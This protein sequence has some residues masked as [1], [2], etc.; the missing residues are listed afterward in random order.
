MVWASLINLLFKMFI[1][2]IVLI[3]PDSPYLSFPLAFPSLGLLYISYYLK[4]NNYSPIFYDLTGGIKLPENL[5]AD[6]FAFSCQITQFKEIINIMKILR[7]DNPNSLFVVG[8]PFPTHSPEE[9]L[10][11]GFD[12]VVIGE[13]ELPIVEIVKKFPD[14]RKGIYSSEKFIDPNEV[15]VDWEAIDVLRY[16]YQLEGKRCINIMTKRGNCPFHCTFCAKHEHGKSPLRFR[17]SEKVLEEA[18]Y[19][20]DKYGFGAI[21]IYDDDVLIDKVRDRQIFKGLYSLGMPYRCMTRVDLAT[22][23]DLRFLKETGCA[24]VCVGIE[25]ADPNIHENVIKKG[26]TI[27]QGTEFIKYCKEIGLR[28]K[29]Y[30]IIGLPSESK[31][32]VQKTREWLAKTKPENFDISIFTPYPGSDIYKNKSK[33][34]IDWDENFLKKV[35]FSGEAQ[36]GDCA[37]YTP[38]L[39]SEEILELKKQIEEEFKREGGGTTLYWGPI[40]N[41]AP[42]KYF[43]NEPFLK[44][45]EKEY[46]LDVLESGWLSVKGKHTKIFEKKF[47]EMVGVKYSLAVQSGTA[48]LHT[49]LLSLGVGKEDKVVIPNYTCAGSATSVIQCGAEPV[50]LDIEKDTFGLNVELLEDYI[51]KEGKPKAIMLVHIYGFPA[52]DTEKIVNLCRKENIFLLEDCCE[53]HGAEYNEKKLGSFGDISV[54]S[55]RSEKMIG[56]GEGGL[57]LTNSKK[58]MDKALYWASRAAN[59]RTN[60]DPYWYKYYY[61]GIG[62]NYLLPHLL[63]AVGRA[64]I[65]NFDEILLR[66]RKVGGKYQE[67]F[68]NMDDIKLQKITSKSK[69][70]YW[71]NFLIL[72][73]KTKEEVRRI[74]EELRNKGIEIRPAFWPLNNQPIFEKYSWGPQSVGNYLFEKGI[75]LPSSV[76]LA[77]DDCKSVDEIYRIFKNTIFF[78]SHKY[79]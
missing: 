4:Q 76:Y 24:E 28:V 46:V 3:Q 69:P 42:L 25:T 50:I 15:S 18:K 31:E 7:E 37:V 36:Y 45:Q 72:R 21:A 23:E 52:R 10:D 30:L 57:I 35:W 62:M 19:L 68:R 60:K 59:H 16:R 20:R 26:T 75:V 64:Q 32:T 22:K 48:A 77:D 41:N 71:L 63:G 79:L 38:Y 27:E 9:C 2:K 53:A 33:Y 17:T 14:V 61:R 5:K 54:F 65:E 67:L 70:S 51:K 49:A 66:K 40:N 11:A 47:A 74:G 13:G 44:G 43:L 78:Q 39:S 58:L 12:A 29:A 56:V 6:I 1:P 8:G 55:V 34:E 73:D